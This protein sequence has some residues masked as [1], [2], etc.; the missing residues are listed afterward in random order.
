[1]ATTAKRV[2][3]REL[4]RKKVAAQREAQ[5]KRDKDNE[6]DLAAI[7]HAAGAVPAAEA[8]R[9]KA[10]VAARDKF[11]RKVEAAHSRIGA[12]LAAMR[13]RGESIAT[14]AELTELSETEVRR[15]LK[16]HTDKATESDSDSADKSATTT[17]AGTAP[18]D[19]EKADA[20][21]LAS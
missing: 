7:L 8:V 15:L 17:A 12:A 11:D 10:I 4:A 1:M 6:N 19:S 5:R 20:A 13:D 21:E 2:S 16:L 18:P 3:A 14:L 9:D